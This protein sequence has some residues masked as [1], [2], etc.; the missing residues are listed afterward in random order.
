MRIWKR[1][2][3]LGTALVLCGASLS[4]LTYAEEDSDGSG[5]EIDT[6]NDLVYEE[7]TYQVNTDGGVTITSCDTA[8]T[9]SEIPSEIDGMQVTAIGDAAFMS[10]SFI[11]NIIVPSGVTEIGESAFS[12]CSML[13]TV[14]LPEGLTT[15]GDGAFESCSMLSEINFPSTLTELSDAL[16]YDCSYLPSIELPS[17]IQKIGNETFYS[18]TTLTSV[19]LSEGLESI[20]DYAFQNCQELENVTIPASCTSLGTYVFDGC[21]MLSWIS[22]AE[23]NTAYMSQDDVLF[24]N[25]GT[26][27]IRYP[28]AKSDTSYTVPDNCTRLEDW[29]F[30]GST[31]LEEI[32]LANVTE[33]GEDCFYYCTALTSIVIPEGVTIL[34]GAVFAY[35]VAL[36]TVT[37]PSTMTTLGDHCFYACTALTEIN[38]PEGVTSI[39]A[40][41]FYNCGNL[42]SLSLPASITEIGEEALGYYDSSETSDRERIDLLVVENAGSE[43]VAEYLESWEKGDRNWMLWLIGGGV[44]LVLAALAVILL[45]VRR[46]RNKIHATSRTAPEKTSK[47]KQQTYSAGKNARPQAKTKQTNQKKKKKK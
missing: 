18:C 41:C 40:R 7:Y 45:L 28:Q 38:V 35:C 17:T 2:A 39:G 43:A 31:V 33:I 24:T 9:I 13:C 10:C 47:F 34:D 5:I 29:C 14:T 22:V 6:S 30:I 23:G 42:L 4:M 3:W 26:T 21:Q 32:D 15:I 44:V 16:F 8:A 12:S 1:F 19:T 46:S 37:L 20:G 11:T 27:M 25:D 36:E